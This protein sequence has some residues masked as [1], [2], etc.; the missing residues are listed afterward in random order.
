VIVPVNPLFAVAPPL[1]SNLFSLFA[2]ASMPCNDLAGTPSSFGILSARLFLRSEFADEAFCA[3][4]FSLIEMVSVSPMKRER[5]SSNSGLALPVWKIAPLPFWT[6]RA[7][8]GR[9]RHRLM[10]ARGRR[11]CHA[12]REQRHDDKK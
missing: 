7:G 11:S 9:R 1:P 3:L 8:S 6:W 10:H 4:F 12:G 5:R 2:S